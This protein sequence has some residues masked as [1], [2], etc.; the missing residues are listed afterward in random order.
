MGGR[1]PPLDLDAEGSVLAALIIQDTTA[2]FDRVAPIVKGHHFYSNANK[3]I[4]DTVS[5]MHLRG[6]RVDLVSIASLLKDRL[7]LDTIGGTPYL[8]TIANSTPAAGPYLEQHARRVRELHR[9][10]SV[11]SIGQTIAAEGYGDV[12]DGQEWIEGIETQISALAHDYSDRRVL[13]AS[14]VA[15]GELEKLWTARQ[16]GQSLTGTSTGF[17]DLDALT[18]GLHDGDL[19]I[20]AGRPG[21]GKTSFLTDLL[22]N[23]A[24]P[25]QG[26]DGADPIIPAATLLFSLE[27]PREQMAM[28]I[29]CSSAGVPYTRIRKGFFDHSDYES[30]LEAIER[31]RF[32]PLFID[33]KPAITLLELKAQCRKLDREIEQGRCSVPAT[34]LGAVGVDYIQLMAAEQEIRRRGSREQ[35]VASFSA[36]LKR[37]AKELSVPVVAASQLNRRVEQR[38]QSKRPDLSDLRESGAIEQDADNIV[39][40]YRAAYYDKESTNRTCEVIVAKQRNGPTGIVKL[41]FDNARTSF[42]SLVGDEYDFEGLE[43]EDNPYG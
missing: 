16:Q 42:R 4:F 20:V 28:R 31:F 29:I 33:D 15:T 36:G 25:I 17:T 7:K 3:I 9:R 1:E 39:F 12:G 30:L 41:Y 5:D 8:H 40:L 24:T 14:E 6:E 35:E 18:S 27:M 43:K 11:I 26:R 38:G 21:M 10:R 22:V 34:R 19:T 32:V 37:L 13:S 23:V 2:A